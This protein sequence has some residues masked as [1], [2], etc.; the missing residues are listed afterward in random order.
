[1]NRSG[2]VGLDAGLAGYIGEGIAKSST[3]SN[4]CRRTPVIRTFDEAAAAWGMTIETPVEGQPP[5]QP[6]AHVVTIR[7]WFEI[8]TGRERGTAGFFFFAS[9]GQPESVMKKKGVDPSMFACEPDGGKLCTMTP[10]LLAS[11]PSTLI[12]NISLPQ[13][14]IISGH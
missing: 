1:M 13:D 5:G 11:R 4:L 7:K 2:G 9:L 6:R 8:G 3:E 12:R 14:S 10:P